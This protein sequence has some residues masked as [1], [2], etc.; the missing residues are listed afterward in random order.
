MP[1][2]LIQ[3]LVAPGVLCCTLNRPGNDNMMTAGVVD[4]LTDALHRAIEDDGCRP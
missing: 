2:D 1:D 3:E 4:G